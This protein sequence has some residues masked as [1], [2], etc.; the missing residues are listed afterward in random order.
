MRNSDKQGLIKI[1]RQAAANLL[2]KI[3][4]IISRP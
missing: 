1:V 4:D 2:H 3:A